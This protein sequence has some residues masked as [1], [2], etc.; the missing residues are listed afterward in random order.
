M[1]NHIK[2]ICTGRQI[3][4]VSC[5]IVALAIAWSPNDTIL[6]LVGNAWAVLVH[7]AHLF[8]FFILE[9]LTREGAISGMILEL[10]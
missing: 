8:F 1:L 9:K 6:N 4:C 7:L 2:R 10:S 3:V 5:A